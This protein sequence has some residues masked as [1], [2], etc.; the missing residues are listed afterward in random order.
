[1]PADL[2]L[3]LGGRPLWLAGL[4]QIR[5]DVQGLADSGCAAAADGHRER[6]ARNHGARRREADAGAPTGDEDN[7]ACRARVPR[8]AP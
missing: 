1:M 6:L 3:R 2:S 8:G 7:L 5:G 4:A